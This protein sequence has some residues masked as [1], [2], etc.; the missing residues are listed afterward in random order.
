MARIKQGIAIDIRLHVKG[1]E[2]RVVIDGVD[3]SHAHYLILKLEG[4]RPPKFLA[5]T[6]NPA[7]IPPEIDKE[8]PEQ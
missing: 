1:E 2:N 6:M 5:G 4:G 7:E 8:S 3:Y